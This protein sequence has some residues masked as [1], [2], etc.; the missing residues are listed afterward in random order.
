MI[1]GIDW[2]FQETLPRYRKLQTIVK[3]KYTVQ[4]LNIDKNY[5]PYKS[6]QG[7]LN[8][9]NGHGC[10]FLKYYSNI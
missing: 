8:D 4:W 6:I 2:G 5:T 1:N 3:G 7:F 9:S 10:Y